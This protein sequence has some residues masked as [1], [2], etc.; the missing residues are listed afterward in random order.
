[1]KRKRKPGNDAGVF[2]VHLVVGDGP[3]L[4]GAVL[5]NR[6]H[7][8]VVKEGDRV[9][10][11]DVGVLD[12]DSLGGLLNA[13]DEDVGV[14]GA[15][16]NVEGVRRPGDGVNLGLVEDPV[17]DLGLKEKKG[18]SACNTETRRRG[19]R[20][21]HISGGELV[22]ND[23]ALGVTSSKVLTVRRVG[24]RNNLQEREGEPVNFV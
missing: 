8:V 1:M 6:D 23:L 7:G 17:R 22:D 19:S 16:G 9:D 21:A 11:A 15:G 14:K 4:G 5:P 10:A 13:P 18:G 24:Q 3:G 20:K 12:L 2:G